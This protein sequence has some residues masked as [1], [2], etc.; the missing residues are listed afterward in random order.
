MTVEFNKPGFIFLI[1]GKVMVE[2]PRLNFTV[3]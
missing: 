2:S 1:L 3:K